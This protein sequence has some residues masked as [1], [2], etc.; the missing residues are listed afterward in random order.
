M[1][2]RVV[3][4]LTV[5][6]SWLAAENHLA[7]LRMSC[8]NAFRVSGAKSCSLRNRPNKRSSS[9]PTEIPLKTLSPEFFTAYLHE[10]DRNLTRM[11]R[12]TRN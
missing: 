7:N 11:T 5:N 2:S 12:M 10:L 9:F 6:G 3:T 4:L 8:L 1:M